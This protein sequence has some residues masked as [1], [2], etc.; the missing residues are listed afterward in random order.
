[1][2]RKP[3]TEDQLLVGIVLT[4]A[5]LVFWVAFLTWVAGRVLWWVV[6]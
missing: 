6:A 4:V 1:M 5:A 2:S 3:L